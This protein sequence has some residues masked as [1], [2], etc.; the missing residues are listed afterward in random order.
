MPEIDKQIVK[1]TKQAAPLA[2]WTR[3]SMPQFN[4][5]TVYEH[6]LK[7]AAQN[8]KRDDFLLSFLQYVVTITRSLGAVYFI[9]NQ[10]KQL[11]VGPQLLSKELLA[12]TPDAVA[13]VSDFAMQSAQQGMAQ[14]QNLK[15]SELACCLVPVSGQAAM[16]EVLVVFADPQQTSMEQNLVMNQLLCGYINIWQQHRENSVL[17]YET[18]S[19]AAM[20]E[21][22]TLLQS[23]DNP[24][25]MELK[26][27]N[28]F[29]NLLACDKVAFGQLNQTGETL[30][31]KSI[32]SLSE[33]DQRSNYASLIEQCFFETRSYQETVVWHADAQQISEQQ[34]QNNLFV[35]HQRLAEKMDAKLVVSF[36]LYDAEQQAWAAVTC[37]WQTDLSD[38]QQKIN[39]IEA[40]SAPLSVCLRQSDTKRNK[41][42]VFNENSL[43]Y[44]NRMQI[45]GGILAALLLLMLFP[46]NHKITTDVQLEPIT[47]RVVSASYDGVLKSILVKPGD[48]V[49]KNDILATLDEREIIWKMQALKAEYQRALKQKDM[50]LATST[51]SEAQIAGLEIQR[52]GLKIKLLQNQINNLEITAPISGVVISGDIEQK[53]GGPV[54]KGQA[55]FEVAP[56]DNMMAELY[57]PADD[58]SYIK[59]D[60][61]L[62][63][64]FD[65]LPGRSW[66][67]KLSS[68]QPR[69]IIRDNEN[70]FLGRV[71]IQEQDASLFK[72]GMQ[73]QAK[74][75][76]GKRALG[77]VLFHKA[78]YR[79]SRWFLMTF[80]SP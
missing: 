75:L 9:R 28:E 80:S 23:S 62:L 22:T 37:W 59:P 64:K 26:F 54:T 27:V 50:K 74:L 78:W 19:T 72:P 7:T 8:S 56:L 47:Q 4:A 11:A 67:T 58:I 65:A 44:K 2:Q 41:L 77:W 29:R 34:G 15:G 5:R 43:W 20:L 16:N 18:S 38:R 63:L 40:A 57:I 71:D 25:Q 51:T 30:K 60:S 1:Q 52:I 49:N 53:Q 24:Q 3:P 6:L 12:A 32:S 76:A 13:R 61:P 69:A 73:G 55:L 70:V 39:L 68:I 48:I 42:F 66:N 14:T 46:V 21:L 35:A 17:E 79:L 36:L 45:G 31:L 10:A 33:F